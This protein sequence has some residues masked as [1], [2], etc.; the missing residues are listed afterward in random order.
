VSND[1][2][3]KKFTEEVRLAS[4]SSDRFEWLVGA[5]YTQEN[6][7]YT[8]YNY[9]LSA[10]YPPVIQSTSGFTKLV[11]N[12]FKEV[13][14][15]TN[16]TYKITDVWDVSVGVRAGENWQHFSTAES[17]PSGNVIPSDCAVTGTGASL[18]QDCHGSAKEHYA[19]YSVDSSYHF[20]DAAMLY[21][22][23]ASGYRPGAPNIPAA[24]AVFAAPQSV[25]PDNVTQYELGVKT[26]WL[27][28]RVRAN[29]AVYQINWN[30]IQLAG[31]E[32]QFYPGTQ[33]PIPG[34][35]VS[36]SV[37]GNGARVRGTE[38]SLGYAPIQSL[39]LGANV[40]YTH[41]YLTEPTPPSSG[42]VVGEPGDSLPMSPLWSG[43]ATADYFHAVFGGWKGDIGMGWRYTGKRYTTIDDNANCALG[44]LQCFGFNTVPVLQGYGVLDAH[45]GLSNDRWSLR[46][47]GRNLAN[48]YVF[49]GLGEG[50]AVPLQPRFFAFNIERSF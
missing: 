9:E 38:L 44:G 22:R 43:S 47:T 49:I 45:M 42:Q 50:V 39:H 48:K 33:N 8:A 10:L 14:L 20:T 3:L 46:L 25:G 28:H 23:I 27:D 16:E 4:A 40:S 1:A 5:F 31:Q 24:N 15:F 18:Q 11:S 13:A 35:I 41:A 7:P 37:N 32:S 26:D 21:G 17:G 2:E 19:T 30:K 12:V 6:A 29:I 34:T 36:Y